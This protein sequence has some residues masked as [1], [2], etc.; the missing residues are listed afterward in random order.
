MRMTFTALTL[1]ATLLFSMIGR[2]Q[3]TVPWSSSSMGFAISSSTTTMVKSDIGQAFVGT[4]QGLSSMV[5]GG[6]LADTLL[7]GTVVSVAGHAAIPTEFALEQ[8]YPNPFNPTTKIQLT[9]PNR[10]WTTVNVYDILGRKVVTLLNEV[11]DPGTYT[12]EFDGSNL[13]SGVYFYR[14]EAGDFKQTKRLLLLK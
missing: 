7:R 5:E 9:I 4:M 10:R 13:S 11:K 2:A 8:N 6:F 14:L 12:I 3:S 1:L